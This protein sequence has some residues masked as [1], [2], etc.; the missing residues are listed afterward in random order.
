MLRD[1]FPLLTSLG[2]HVI[3]NGDGKELASLKSHDADPWVELSKL[4]DYSAWA[5]SPG[6]K[7][8]R[9]KKKVTLLNK[10]RK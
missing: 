4:R 2:S 7:S 9:Y 10:G 5:L 3:T 1:K 8:P 6:L